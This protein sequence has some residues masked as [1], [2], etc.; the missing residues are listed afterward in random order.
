[1]LDVVLD[2]LDGYSSKGFGDRRIDIK[3]I[4]GGQRLEL[5][6]LEV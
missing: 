6:F 5:L 4:S 2:V 3:V 1:M